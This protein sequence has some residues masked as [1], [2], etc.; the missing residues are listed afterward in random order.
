MYFANLLLQHIED[1]QKRSPL[2]LCEENKQNEWEETVKLLQK[3]SSKPVSRTSD[4]FKYYICI[5]GK[6]LNAVLQH[7]LWPHAP[8]ILLWSVSL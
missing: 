1:Q 3:C 8:P 5:V 4:S 2:Q 6:H 7:S